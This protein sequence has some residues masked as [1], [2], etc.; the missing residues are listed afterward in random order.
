MPLGYNKRVECI[1]LR[2][3]IRDRYVGVFKRFGINIISTPIKM[4]VIDLAIAIQPNEKCPI[5]K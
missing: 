4:G 5:Y 2:L 1:I 3:E